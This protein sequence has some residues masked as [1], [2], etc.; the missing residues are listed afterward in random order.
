MRP[1]VENKKCSLSVG[2]GKLAGPNVELFDFDLDLGSF[3]AAERQ[4]L[5]CRVAGNREQLH[6]QHNGIVQGKKEH[7]KLAILE[8]TMGQTSIE[9][10]DCFN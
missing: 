9:K 5:R 10:V 6:Q 2:S 3:V 8:K 7:T 1:F 4:I